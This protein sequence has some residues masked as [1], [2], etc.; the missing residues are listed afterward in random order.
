VTDNAHVLDLH[1]RVLRIDAEWWCEVCALSTA[2]TVLYVIDRGLVGRGARRGGT[3][4]LA[5]GLFA[6]S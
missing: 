4:P 1:I 3:E 6:D 5:R 2:V